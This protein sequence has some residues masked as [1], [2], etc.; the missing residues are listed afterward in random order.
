MA[1]PFVFTENPNDLVQVTMAG[2][3]GAGGANK[4]D[5]VRLIQT[6]LNAV[7]SANA[8]RPAAKLAID[9]RVGPKT[10]DAI[11][12]FQTKYTGFVDGRVDPGKKTI[13][14]LVPLLRANNAL[15]VGVRGLGP[16]DAQVSRLF[17]VSV[18]AGKSGGFWG[19]SPTPWKFVSSGNV[20]ISFDVFGVAAGSFVIQSDAQPG[21]VKRL[22]FSGFGVGVSTLPIG[23]DVAFE[24]M[25]S[26][27]TRIMKGLIATSSFASPQDFVGPCNFAVAGGNAGPGFAGTAVGFT[28]GLIATAFGGLAGMQA[29]LPG[30]EFSLFIGWIQSWS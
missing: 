2:S 19:L 17:A 11:R 18:G 16:P 4:A 3:V 13:R 27:G 15:P 22:K 29:G 10:I 5:D 1:A 25:P 9:G 24:S 8:L 7:P 20:S 6:L 14:A 30:F 26:W 12:Q 28:N 21:A 23:L